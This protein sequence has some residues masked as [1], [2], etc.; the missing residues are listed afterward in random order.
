[1]TPNVIVTLQEESDADSEPADD[2]KWVNGHQKVRTTLFGA[3]IAMDKLRV[4]D[5]VEIVWYMRVI[6]QGRCF[7][8]TP[9]RPGCCLRHTLQLGKGELAQLL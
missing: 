2:A 3:K 6:K 1:M 7:E 8:L 9:T 5:F 4:S